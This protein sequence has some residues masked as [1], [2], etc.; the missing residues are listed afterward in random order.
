MGL[1][2]RTEKL[3]ADVRAALDLDR[4]DRVLAH[5][6]LEDGSWAV[7]T[8]ASLIRSDGT[9]TAAC[10]WTDVDRGAWDPTTATLTVTW[11]DGS[12]PLVLTVA[13]PRRTALMRVFRERVQASVVMSETVALGPGLTA[14]VAVRKDLHGNL[15]TQVVGDAGADMSDPLVQ[16]AVRSALARLRSASG[17]PPEA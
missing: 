11:V 6:R 3:P 2:S 4:G 12:P 10:S 7:A 8:A 1:L 14:R 13:D 5:G 15:V 9:S 17:A 16:A